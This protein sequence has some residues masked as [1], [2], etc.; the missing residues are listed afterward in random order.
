M[1]ILA[2]HI[3]ESKMTKDVELKESPLNKASK[4]STTYLLWAFFLPAAL[5]FAIYAALGT[6]PFGESSVLVLDLNGQYVFFFE[7][8]RDLV[9]G[10]GDF[11]Y[12]FGRALGGEFMGIYAYYLASP[13]SYIVCLFPK[14]AILEALYTMFVDRKSVV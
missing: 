12:S 3:K 8:L 2:N 11:L 9:Y 1:R 10:E 4:P 6:Y 14:H 7:A 5:M 13:L